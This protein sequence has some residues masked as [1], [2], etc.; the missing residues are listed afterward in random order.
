MDMKPGFNA[1]RAWIGPFLLGVALIHTAVGLW[2]FHGTVAELWD[3]GWWDS[4]G[5][6]PLRGAVVWFFLFGAPLALLA[7]LVRP[8]QRAAQW[9]ALRHLGWGLLGLLALGASL[10]P[11][12]GFWLVLPPAL[13]LCVAPALTPAP[14]AA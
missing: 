5:E 8:L 6:H 11:V 10:M 2:L 14:L 3:L 1:G 13:A 12:S 9:P 4:V 7:G